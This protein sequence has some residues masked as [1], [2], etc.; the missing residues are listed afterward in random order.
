MNKLL[1]NGIDELEWQELCDI[2]AIQGSK[3]PKNLFIKPSRHAFACDLVTN[4]TLRDDEFGDEVAMRN[5]KGA[6]SI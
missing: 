3:Q 5:Q 1:Y 2:G 6:L 4:K